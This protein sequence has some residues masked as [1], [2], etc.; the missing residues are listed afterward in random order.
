M[1]R[2][3]IKFLVFVALFVTVDR[4]IS[5]GINKL[6]RKTDNYPIEYQNAFNKIL[7][8]ID[9]D[10]VIIGESRSTHS[11]IPQLIKDSLGLSCI[12]AGKDGTDFLVQNFCINRMLDR[13]QPKVI[14]WE[15]T[16]NALTDIELEDELDRM[17]A[18]QPFY[19][20]P[21]AKQLINQRSKYEKFKMLSHLYRWNGKLLGIIKI[22]IGNKQDNGTNGYMPLDE[23]RHPTKLIDIKYDNTIVDSRVE[24]MRA[25]LQR[26]NRCGVL[27][28]V[29]SSPVYYRSNMRYTKQFAVF[30]EALKEEHTC[31]LDYSED[32]YF[33]ERDDLFY[34]IDHLN[35]NGAI[36]YMQVFIPQLKQMLIHE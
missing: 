2:L 11:Y 36:K 15:L 34:D 1:K 24:A 17:N 35:N 21:E 10:V 13:Y 3:I 23:S 20:I 4:I 7:Y 8:N 14:I 27:L 28:V 25:T 32:Q 18:L 22:L 19:H 5:Y 6:Y 31:W 9:E 26:V 16:P 29:V 12:N 30:H 33:I